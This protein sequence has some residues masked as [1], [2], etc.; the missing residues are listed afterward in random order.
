MSSQFC[1]NTE[2]TT[3]LDID[4]GIEDTASAAVLCQTPLGVQAGGRR[5][6]GIGRR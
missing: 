4:Y 1:I 3:Y 6:C 5:R 2:L